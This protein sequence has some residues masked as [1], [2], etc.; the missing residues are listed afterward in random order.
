VEVFVQLQAR[1][2]VI[3]LV[4]VS[5]L[6]FGGCQKQKTDSESLRILA[7]INPLADFAR[8]VGG[9]RVEV[10][11]LIPTGASPHT[12][13]LTPKMMVSASH[14][15][16][17]ILNGIGLEPWADDL[18]DAVSSDSLLVVETASD[19]EILMDD[20]HAAGNPHVW[21][22][23]RLAR[24]Q[25]EK[26]A[27]ALQQISP[28]DSAYFAINAQ[29]YLAL[30]DTLDI[31]IR[32]HAQK[33]THRSLICVHPA[34]EYFTRE[35]SLELT[36]VVLPNP[37]SEPSPRHLQQVIQAIR[38]VQARAIFSEPQFSP[39][40]VHTIAAET[41]VRVLTLDPLG[42]GDYLALMR[43]NLANIDQALKEGPRCQTL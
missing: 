19:I 20:D 38:R 29:N 2:Y 27:A 21:L 24:Q 4:A 16:L 9:E 13:E 34:W 6:L 5:V 10:V 12:F 35:Y 33:W 41:G 1:F 30:L 3:F 8:Q 42:T 22:N 23:P 43:Q 32:K 15:R 39:A 14:S 28:A 11:V 31:D 40:L 37:G 7:S 36:Q 18:I 17:L 26:I 25:V